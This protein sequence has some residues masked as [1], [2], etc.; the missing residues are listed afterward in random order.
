MSSGTVK[1]ANRKFSSIKNDFCIVF[2]RNAE[3]T[4]VPDD[5]S[6]KDVGFNFVKI[7]NIELNDKSHAVD[8]LAV[9]TDT[10]KSVEI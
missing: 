10:G 8:V 5:S 4:E 1:L 2:D 3:I 7:G 9:V 6:I